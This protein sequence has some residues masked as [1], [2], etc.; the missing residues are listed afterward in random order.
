MAHDEFVA[1]GFDAQSIAD[2]L[3]P[4]SRFCNGQRDNYFVIDTVGDV[5]YCDGVIG[6]QGHIVF[7]V[8]DE[9]TYEQL[10]GVSHDPHDNEKCRACHLLPICQGNCD[11]E[12][13]ATNMVCHPLLTTLPDYLRDYRSCFDVKAE[14][15]V[16]LA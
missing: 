16:R 2:L 4:V 11:W 6:E 10:H 1:G 14:G 13:R 15:Y 3:R 12:R 5:Y 7:N 9:P 8:K